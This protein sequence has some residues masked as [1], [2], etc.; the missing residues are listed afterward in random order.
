MP[1]GRPRLVALSSSCL[2]KKK[3][4]GPSLKMVHLATPVLLPV[5]AM[6]SIIHGQWTMLRVLGI[7]RSPPDTAPPPKMSY[8]PSGV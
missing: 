4:K 7:F 8:V 2:K 1:C 5:I 3:K 6:L